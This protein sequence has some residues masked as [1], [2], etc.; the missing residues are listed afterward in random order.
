MPRSPSPLKAKL[1][2]ALYNPRQV[3]SKSSSSTPASSS[4]SSPDSSILEDIESPDTLGD[5]SIDQLI[6]QGI[7]ELNRLI[8]S[9][10]K[11][12]RD[13]SSTR[14]RSNRSPTAEGMAASL[15]QSTRFCKGI[16]DEASPISPYLSPALDKHSS[17]ELQL[18]KRHQRARDNDPPP[19]APPA[20]DDTDDAE[21]SFELELLKLRESVRSQTNAKKTE[22]DK[23]KDQAAAPELG[24]KINEKTT[25]NIR[26]VSNAIDDALLLV[27]QPFEKRRK[28]YIKQD[29]EEAKAEAKDA[30]PE[31]SAELPLATQAIVEQLNLTF[32]TMTAQRNAELKAGKDA[33]AEA[34]AVEEA[35][36]K[37]AEARKASEERAAKEKEMDILSLIPMRGKLL[38]SSLDI[39]NALLRLEIAETRVNQTVQTITGSN[40]AAAVTSKAEASLGLQLENELAT[41]RQQTIRRIRNIEQRLQTPQEAQAKIA[42]KY[43]RINWDPADFVADPNEPSE[44][45]S[46]VPEDDDVESSE[47]FH[48]VLQRNI[49]QNLDLTILKLKHVLHIDAK[50][51]AEAK[52]VKARGDEENAKKQLEQN[53]ESK[54]R[55][56]ELED[57][58]AARK[59]V[60]GVT[61]LNQISSWVDEET[62]LHDNL[63]QLRPVMEQ[64]MAALDAWT[65]IL[66]EAVDHSSLPS[67]FESNRALECFDAIKGAMDQPHSNQTEHRQ[68]LHDMTLDDEYDSSEGSPGRYLTEHAYAPVS[69]DLDRKPSTES[70]QDKRYQRF[71]ANQNEVEDQFEFFSKR[72]HELRP[73]AGVKKQPHNI[74][75]SSKA[76]RMP[77]WVDLRGPKPDQTRQKSQ[78]E[79]EVKESSAVSR[80]QSHDPQPAQN[81]RRQN[82]PDP[83][84]TYKEQ[85]RSSAAE[86]S[87]SLSRSR[88]IKDTHERKLS[89]ARKQ[90]GPP[91]HEPTTIISRI[92]QQI[93]W[94]QHN[95]RLKDAWVKQRHPH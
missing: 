39:E 60:M 13:K 92:Q 51:A 47:T 84:P 72:F 17:F 93:E 52:E 50:E 43:R 48:E 3:E 94:F 67:F 12:M 9:G 90:T 41:L 65:G 74:H 42:L 77:A 44:E 88:T 81:E 75:R 69:R 59:Q 31:L 1:S 64:K 89:Q 2:R 15:T 53:Q 16:F 78:K 71:S 83:R 26:D 29:E 56:K 91:Q 55:K 11:S 23:T 34:K 32:G 70:A 8:S 61:S 45:K 79:L 6:D 28:E 37:D 20:D 57:A 14:E 4:L 35:K 24:T 63:S 86:L 85:R 7:N 82:R 80:R 27:L 19:P 68:H 73:T 62:Q 30:S 58:E 18:P 10:R 49:V 54:R 33:A 46:V 87:S 36:T 95:R 38:A 76:T 5:D 21:N 25:A 22:N 40:F 66:Q